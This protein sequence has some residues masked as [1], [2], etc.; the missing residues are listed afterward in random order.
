LGEGKKKN[1]E[2]PKLAVNLK[3]KKP[4]KK[5]RSVWT[6]SGGGMETSRR[7]H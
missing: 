6:I 2:A 3:A 4:K 7:R 1:A 5:R